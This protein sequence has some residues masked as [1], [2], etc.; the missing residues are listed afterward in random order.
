MAVSFKSA[1]FPKDVIL[2]CI[3]VS[4]Q[5]VQIVPVSSSYKLIIP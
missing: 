4:V 5:S 1:H 2:T 3:G